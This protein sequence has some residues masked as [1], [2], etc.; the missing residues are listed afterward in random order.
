VIANRHLY[1]GASRARHL[2]V[3]LTYASDS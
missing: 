3:E 1:I 2:L